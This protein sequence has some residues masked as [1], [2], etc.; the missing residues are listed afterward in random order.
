MPSEDSLVEKSV[1]HFLS[2]WLMWAQDIVDYSGDTWRYKKA[3]W[4]N[5]KKN[6]SLLLFQ[7]LPLGSCLRF[8]PDFPGWGTKR[9]KLKEI[10]NEAFHWAISLALTLHSLPIRPFLFW[11]RFFLHQLVRLSTVGIWIYR[12]NIGT[13]SW[14][15]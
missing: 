11:D 9:C 10:S 5:K 7:F 14:V 6:S 15:I 4:E 13:D 8:C 2:W 12:S 3:A 1:I